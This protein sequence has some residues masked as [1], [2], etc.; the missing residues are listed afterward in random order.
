MKIVIIEDDSYTRKLIVEFLKRDGIE[1][2]GEDSGVDALSYI[3][4]TMPDII[5]LDLNL[6]GKS[7]YEICRIIRENPQIY[8]NPI[9]LML[10]GEIDSEKVREGFMT[11]ADD[12]IKKPFDIEELMLRVHSWSRRINKIEQIIKYREIMLDI[13]NKNVFINNKPVNVSAKEFQLLRYMIINKG[14]TVSRDKLMKEVWEVEYYY[15]CKTVDMTIKR[16]KEKIK[17]LE[18]L[19]EP[20]TGIGYKLIK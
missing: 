11:G 10:T 5:I 19:I 4:N 15:G 7:G 13:E 12:Y 16:I 14:L 18:Q 20:V 2:I 6:P 8:G 9:I 17:I 3:I 1:S